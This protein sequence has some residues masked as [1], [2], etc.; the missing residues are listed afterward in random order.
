MIDHGWVGCHIFCYMHMW[1]SL[2]HQ[3]YVVNRAIPFC[4][5]TIP[6][7]SPSRMNRTREERITIDGAHSRVLC[8]TRLQA[9]AAVPCGQRPLPIFC[10]SGTA[11]DL[12]P[13]QL[14][15]LHRCGVLYW[16]GGAVAAVAALSLLYM[17]VHFVFSSLAQQHRDRDNSRG[18][19]WGKWDGDS[20][21]ERD[22]D[23]GA[24]NVIW[25]S[26]VPILPIHMMNST[27][28][29]SHMLMI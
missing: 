15:G 13:K 17:N 6:C 20:H 18:V 5:A 28:T 19:S 21:I 1:T 11:A 29:C 24:K 10:A 9:G 26:P 4:S 25:S 16:G 27:P 2:V 22:G 7:S 14:A 23:V 3:T 8:R 12:S